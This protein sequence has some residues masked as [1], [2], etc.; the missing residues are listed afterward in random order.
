MKALR[1]NKLTVIA[2]AHGPSPLSAC[3]PSPLFKGRGKLVPSLSREGEGFMAIIALAILVGMLA[4]QVRAGDVVIN[5]VAW[6]GHSGY[7]SDEWIELKNTTGSPIDLTGWKIYDE[8]AST[9]LITL[10]GSIGANGFFLVESGDD[11]TVSNIAG[12][13]V[14]TF[15]SDLSDYGEH[16]QLKDATSVL[17]D[18]VNCS[19]S[20]WFAGTGA[21]API[22]STMERKDPGISGNLS[23]NW[24]SNDGITTN[25]LDAGSNPINGTARS[26]NS[27]YSVAPILIN[28]NF[29][30]SF[31]PAGWC[32]EGG[33]VADTVY[34]HSPNTSAW[35][36]LE[37]DT[38]IT[39]LLTSP[40]ILFYW[41]RSTGLSDLSIQWSTVTDG[42]W[43]HLPGS[44][45]TTLFSTD[46]SLD[47]NIFKKRAFDITAF[48]D[49]YIRFSP[50]DG[51]AGLKP[52]WIDDVLV[53]VKGAPKPPADRFDSH[54]GTS[55][56]KGGSAAA[57]S[58]LLQL[59]SPAQEW[60]VDFL[61]S[62]GEWLTEG[63]ED[64]STRSLIP[65]E[66]FRV[67][68]RGEMPD[69]SSFYLGAGLKMD[70]YYHDI[71]KREWNEQTINPGY[72]NWDDDAVI[73]YLSYNLPLEARFTQDLDNFPSHLP[74]TSQPMFGGMEGLE[75]DWIIFLDRDIGSGP[76]DVIIYFDNQDV[77]TGL[78]WEYFAPISKMG[79]PVGSELVISPGSPFAII[80]FWNPDDSYY[81]EW[82]NWTLGDGC[83]YQNGG[84]KDI[85]TYLKYTSD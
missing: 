4:G 38:L 5:E 57:E 77:S 62:S 60:R 39:P 78:R 33:T 26:Q 70:G 65:E 43:Y 42:A 36:N 21:G 20:G 37:Y 35:M 34:F 80:Q 19:S 8:G 11:N 12:D 63:S 46:T 50:F 28:E 27:A 22:C 79:D 58:T 18:E 17:I 56:F 6:A 48:E 75:S 61:H 51:S 72:P 47:P 81:G 74:G 67:E 59:W 64:T 23:T 69:Y 32:I 7:E 53:T 30:G 2:P 25:G 66:G 15:S 31:P 45:K 14:G 55:F 54:L 82:S 3:K 52:Y 13:T 40:G 83:P 24:A 29:E 10:D 76:E 85:K 49:I 1:K 44:P 84:T 68:F 9:V 41:C 73:T 71:Y 16:L